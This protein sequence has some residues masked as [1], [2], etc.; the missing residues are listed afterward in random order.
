MN[1][2]NSVLIEGTLTEN[3]VCGKEIDGITNASFSIESHRYYQKADEVGVEKKTTTIY[4]SATGKLADGVAKSGKK[5]RGVRVVGR[6]AQTANTLIIEAEHVEFRP[7]P[8]AETEAT[9]KAESFVA[10]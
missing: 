5:G 7:L 9:E 4:V 1:N 2:L 3:A 8:K 10:A 6:L